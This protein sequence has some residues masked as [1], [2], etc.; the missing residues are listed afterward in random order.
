MTT[1]KNCKSFSNL[2]FS[3]VRDYEVTL[4][5]L[6]IGITTSMLLALTFCVF[7]ISLMQSVNGA[8]FLNT[9]SISLLLFATAGPTALFETV[10]VPLTSIYA[11]L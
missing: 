8:Q 7:F 5:L 11:S 9:T 3:Y 2:Y 6:Y 4:A 1:F 10:I